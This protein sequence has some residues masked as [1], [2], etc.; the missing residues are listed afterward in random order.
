MQYAMVG[1]Q[2]PRDGAIASWRERIAESFLYT[3][4]WNELFK[5]AVPLQ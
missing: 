4:L 3:I 5:R 2:G 1:Y